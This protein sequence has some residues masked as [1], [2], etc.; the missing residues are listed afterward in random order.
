MRQISISN[1]FGVGAL[2]GLIL[3]VVWNPLTLAAATE[4]KRKGRKATEN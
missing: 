1:T 2:L 4:T 3:A